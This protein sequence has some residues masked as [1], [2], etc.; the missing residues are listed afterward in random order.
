MA[1]SEYYNQVYKMFVTYFGRPPAESGLDYYAGLLDE[2]GGDLAVIVDDFYNSDESAAFFDGKTVEGQVNQVFQNAFG[3]D[4]EVDGLNYWA[5]EVRTGEIAVSQLAATVAFNADEADTAVLDAK[6]DTAEE[7]VADLDTTTKI[8]EYQT[9]AGKDGAREFLS[10]VATDTPATAEEVA[11]G[12]TEALSG[13]NVNP[14]DTFTLTTGIDALEGTEDD[15]TFIGT[16]DGNDDV[17]QA[18]RMGTFGSNMNSPWAIAFGFTTTDNGRTGVTTS[19][20]PTEGFLIGT[21]NF[22]KTSS[23]TLGIYYNA[24]GNSQ[25]VETN[26]S[27]TDGNDYVVIL[28]NE[29]TQ[30]K[31]DLQFYFEPGSPADRNVPS[32]QTVTDPIDFPSDWTYGAE[33]R[34]GTLKDYWDVTFSDIYW[35]SDSLNQ[36]ERQGIFDQYSWYNPNNDAP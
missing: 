7:W 14:G 19:S 27:V 2:N 12:V 10:S 16:A 15:D 1:V 9:D 17:G 35:F 6:V 30:P 4:A 34:G 18:D 3:R 25:N 24:N 22:D 36:S 31:D 5:N 8:L 13:A 11:A 28:N 21:D 29:G 26:V 23:D 33:N 20:N 32:A